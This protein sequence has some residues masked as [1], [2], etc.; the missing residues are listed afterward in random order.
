[1][2][3]KKLTEDDKQEILDLYRQT[4][5]TT[6]TLAERFAVSSSTISRFLK[7]SLSENEYEVL[8]QQKRLARASKGD[9]QLS[10]SLENS[11]NADSPAEPLAIATE[12]LPT[13]LEIVEVVKSSMAEAE[14]TAT[15]ENPIRVKTRKR[16][17]TANEREPE[18]PTE[19]V[20]EIVAVNSVMP[21]T[22]SDMLV[23]KK[24]SQKIILKSES[25][26]PQY[27]SA[28][29]ENTVPRPIALDATDLGEL[30]EELGKL[31]K[32]QPELEDLDDELDLDD[33]EEEDDWQEEEEASF[34]P[35]LSGSGDLTVLPLSAAVF[36]TTCYLVVDRTAEL[37]VRPLKEFTHLGKIPPEETQQK[38][39]PVFDNHR[40]ARRFSNRTQRVIKVPNSN[41]LRK[42]SSHL[43]A[44]GIT[45]IFLDGRVYS[46]IN[47]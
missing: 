40:V 9:S 6:S 29:A 16:R 33:D 23:E 21:A 34:F 7:M 36:P 35:S 14:E 1:M 27:L 39:L 12:T 47:N 15:E 32:I 19:A 37:I 2:S 20:T 5:E 42:A 22:E 46:L 13:P 28:I 4:P 10:L 43:K 8:I 25:M 44:K 18:L 30:V 31:P 26:T 38:T 17:S 45:R 41:V 11:V 24:I 3:P